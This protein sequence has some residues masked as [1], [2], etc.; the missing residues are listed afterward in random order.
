MINMVLSACN[1]SDKCDDLD[2]VVKKKIENR[3]QSGDR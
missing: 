3:G 2:R 1:E